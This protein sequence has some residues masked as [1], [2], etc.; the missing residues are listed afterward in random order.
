MRLTALAMSTTHTTVNSADRSG[1]SRIRSRNG[2]RS[3]S[4]DTPASDSTAPAATMPAT[5]A[6][7]DTGRTSSS[8]PT[9]QM[10]V[11]ATSSPIISVGVAKAAE[12]SPIPQAT[13]RP[14]TRPAIM[15][16]PPRAGMAYSWTCLSSGATT[17]LAPA[18]ARRT[19]GVASAVVSAAATPTIR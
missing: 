10:S 11:A 6:G 14:T 12:K 17:R 4:S 7:A 16:S 9:V 8:V 18:A 2:T 3:T 15:A 19:T 5:L 13:A 1:D